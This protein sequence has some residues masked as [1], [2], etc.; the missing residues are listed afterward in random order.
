MSLANLLCAA[1]PDE[2][3]AAG[4]L[5]RQAGADAVIGMQR[6]MR[7]NFSGEVVFRPAR[8]EEA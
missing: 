2:G 7:F 1:Q 6:H 5:R 8:P 4:R 3:L